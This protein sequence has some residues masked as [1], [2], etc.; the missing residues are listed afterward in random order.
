MA[1]AAE[2]ATVKFG[3]AAA[4]ET[5]MTAETGMTSETEVTAPAEVQAETEGE[6]ADRRHPKQ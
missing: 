4:I 3:V 1:V 6:I 5:G 2:V